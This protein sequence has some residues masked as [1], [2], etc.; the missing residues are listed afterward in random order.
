MRRAAKSKGLVATVEPLLDDVQAAGCRI[1]A[2]VRVGAL[3]DGGGGV[4]EPGAALR[5]AA[6]LGAELAGADREQ[7]DTDRQAWVHDAPTASSVPGARAS[8]RE[9][10]RA[11][12]G[13]GLDIGRAGSIIQLNR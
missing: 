9:Q 13:M 11:S 7:R 5:A 2:R 10:R 1:S 4:V 12:A 8:E 3:R 6:L